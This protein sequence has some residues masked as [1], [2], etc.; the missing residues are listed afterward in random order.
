MIGA[1]D[2]AIGCLT[3]LLFIIL[4]PLLYV[5]LKLSLMIAVPLAIIVAA[6]LGTAILGRIVRSIFS[7]NKL[8]P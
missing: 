6:I 3:I 7:K 1:K 2:F 4:V 8:N 5:G